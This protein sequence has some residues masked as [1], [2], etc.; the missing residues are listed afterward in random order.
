MEVLPLTRPSLWPTRQR[1]RKCRNY[2][3]FFLVVDRMYCSYECAG[4]PDPR[5]GLDPKDAPRC[6]RVWVQGVWEW[7]RTY[8]TMGDAIARGPKNTVTY[9]CGFCDNWHLASFKEIE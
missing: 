4:R 6:C 2:F 7:K 3:G 9:R 5:E 1:C 8:W